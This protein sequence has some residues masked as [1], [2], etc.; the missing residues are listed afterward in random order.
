[1]HILKIN[2]I[3]I[4]SSSSIIIIA[5]VTQKKT[6]VGYRIIAC[7]L[8]LYK[9]LHLKPPAPGLTELH[10]PSPLWINL[11]SFQQYAFFLWIPVYYHNVKL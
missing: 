8:D 11:T 3:I 7:R 10:C 2:I 5:F 9:G 6:D 1:M 4:I